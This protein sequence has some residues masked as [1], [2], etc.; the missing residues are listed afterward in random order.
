MTISIATEIGGAVILLLALA[1][2]FAF[3]HARGSKIAREDRMA[4][5]ARVLLEFKRMSQSDFMKIVDLDGRDRRRFFG[6][7]G[8]P[9]WAQ[10]KRREFHQRRY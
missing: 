7:P 9:T 4:S 6:G 10:W 2:I 8:E 1:T 5:N 3:A